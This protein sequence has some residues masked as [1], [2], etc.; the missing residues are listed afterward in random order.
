MH[1]THHFTF[2]LT[3]LLLS[4]NLHHFTS[5]ENSRN[6]TDCRNPQEKSTVWLRIKSNV[7]TSS[8][9]SFQEIQDKIKN[10]V[11]YPDSNFIVSFY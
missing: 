11:F 7:T 6:V 4:C 8:T 2:F 5:A 10:K 1:S 3:H 9:V